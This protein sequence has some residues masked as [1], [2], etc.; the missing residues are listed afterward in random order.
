MSK[1][2]HHINITLNNISIFILIY[3]KYKGVLL[4]TG[5]SKYMCMSA[6]TKPTTVD[7]ILR[8]NG[9]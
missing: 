7:P 1:E 4:M 3:F 6:K 2:Y 8:L 9:K 5:Y